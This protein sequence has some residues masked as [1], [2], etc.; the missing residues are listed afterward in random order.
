MFIVNRVCAV[1]NQVMGCRQVPSVLFTFALVALWCGIG[2]RASAQEIQPDDAGLAQL[3]NFEA[4]Q[5]KTAPA[6]WGGGPAGTLFA[7]DQVVHGGK[8]SARIERKSDSPQEFS[9]LTKSL[10]MDFRGERVEL[11]GFVRTEEVSGY[12]GLWMREDGEDPSLAFDN[13]AQRQVKGTTDWTEYTI[14]L[15]VHPQGRKLFFGF[16]LSGTGKAWADDLQLLVDGKPIWQA[17][18]AEP[19]LTILDRDREFDAGSKI[20]LSTLTPVQIGNLATLGKV[21]GFLKYH[22]PKVTA[23]TVH[24]DYALFRVLPAVLAA[25]DRVGANAAMLDW[26]DGLG[27]IET[28]GLAPQLTEEEL[29]LRRELAWLDDQAQLGAELSR[30]LREI[31]ANRS[32]SQTQFHAT[33]VP[34]V[35]N[36]T[37][38]HE[39]GYPQLKD[40]DAGFQ[41]L[42]LYR[43][44]NIIRYWFPYRDLITE[45]WDAV[46]AEY[47]PRVG[48]VATPDAYK[49][50]MMS[51]IARIHDTHANLWSSLRVQ[52]P[53]GDSQLPVIVRFIGSQATVTG[54]VALPD[55]P[56]PPLAVGDIIEQIDGVPVGQLV[57]TWTP[58][59]A[60]SNQP[61][62]LR[63]VARALTRGPAG[64][65]QLTVRRGDE[66]LALTGQRVPLKSVAGKIPRT[67]DRPGETFQLLSKEVA[68]V[69]LSSI[70]AGE[71]RGFIERA[72]GTKRLVI[73]LRNYPSAFTVFELGSLLVDQPTGFARFTTADLTNP[74]AFHFTP[75]LTLQPKAPHY[76]GR[77]VILVDEVSQSSAEYTAMAFRAAPG[78]VVVGSTTAGAD[79]NVSRIPLP[80]G[81]H[82]MISGIGVFYPDKRPTQ[83]IGIVP[84]IEVKPTIEGIKA[85]RDEVLEEALRQILGPET[86][87]EEITRLALVRG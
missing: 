7:D 1:R 9:A 61:T 87:A 34:G 31:H 68:Y 14:T 10:P 15:P 30:R 64:A 22:H 48:L 35:G 46:L 63:D 67:H 55:A 16:L 29:H 62:R 51:L 69:K 40:S 26:I 71:A 76:A 20:A 23:G 77:V 2:L 86:P 73:D 72:A 79:G 17:P 36:L 50:E 75:V 74:G 52:P 19:V 28:G 65:V 81:L 56:L 8:W 43:F 18:K 5:A 32:R 83:R 38:A 59:Y 66:T 49:R 11:R 45:D 82:S 58:L 60:A 4:A 44:W 6:G 78:A 53:V 57:E 13:M 21:W 33:P 47:I 24:W 37:F 80:G 39:P 27:K 54:I 25:P 42:A 85:G 12:V 84:D 3:L 41:L 70:K